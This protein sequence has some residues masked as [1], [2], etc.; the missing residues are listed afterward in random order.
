M[1]KATKQPV[2]I[3]SNVN[4]RYLTGV[5]G[6]AGALLITEDDEILICRDLPLAEKAGIEN[7]VKQ[8]KTT[9]GS[10]VRVLR[11]NKIKKLGVD[12]ENLSYPLYDKFSSSKIKLVSISKTLREMRQVKD[13]N[14]IKILKKACRL[15]DRA[16]EKV[17]EGL[18][19]GVTERE[20]RE[21]ICPF[22]KECEW[23]SFEPLLLSGEN[24]ECIHCYPTDRR[25]KSGD[26]VIVDIGFRVKGY[27]S[28]LTRTFC[29][30]P[31]KEQ[32]EL[33]DKVKEV[34]DLALKNCKI[35]VKTASLH[36]MVEKKFGKMSKYFPYSLGHGVGLEIHESPRINLL[37]KDKLLE[38]MVFTIEPG[39]HVPGLGGCRI[40]DTVLLTKRGVE[41][42]TKSPY[43]LI[44]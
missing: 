32:K 8:E 12:M 34:Q 33:Y 17:M 44:V 20:L 10:L 25:I 37:T 39:L 29:I 9:F 14:E 26:M 31:S 42:L 41:K 18:S 16:M 27:H 36:K 40:E 4:I 5:P 43:E 13:E 21:S 15:A 24:S 23:F 2:A 38:N 1:R 22:L 7:I 6:L 35:G 28:D 30:N 11:Q 3:L 19:E